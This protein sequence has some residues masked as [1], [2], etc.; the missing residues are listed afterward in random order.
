MNINP[1]KLASIPV[2][3]IIGLVTNIITTDPKN[4]VKLP[5]KDD[6]LILKFIDIVSTS[7][8][9]LDSTSPVSC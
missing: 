6:K 9:T 8:V 2:T 4:S 5:I 7:F 3:A 1:T